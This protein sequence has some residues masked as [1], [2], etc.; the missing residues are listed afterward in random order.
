MSPSHTRCPPR[1]LFIE[2]TYPFP[3][4]PFPLYS[5]FLSLP[6]FSLS[7]HNL[8]LS[9]SLP[10]F[11][12]LFFE[13]LDWITKFSFFISVLYL[14]IWRCVD[15]PLSHFFLLC[16][17]LTAYLSLY[18]LSLPLT[19]RVFLFTAFLPYIASEKSILLTQGQSA[20]MAT[21]PPLPNG[22]A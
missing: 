8:S 18:L 13:L 19:R 21:P 5:L 9:I 2:S 4:T 3:F 15:S 22:P 12:C 11:L 20:A 14:P 7:L 6:F 17:S 10:F 16:L 1:T